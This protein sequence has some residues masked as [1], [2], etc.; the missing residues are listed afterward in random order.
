MPPAATKSRIWLDH[1]ATT[2]PCAQAVAAAAAALALPGNPASL[3][4][5]GRA[6]R[7]VLETAREAVAAL[8]GAAPEQVILTSGG[9]EALALAL[10]TPARVLALATEHSAVRAARPDAE[11]L[12]VHASGLIDLAALEAA[13]QSRGPLLVAV[14]HANNETGVVQ[15]IEAVAALCRQHGA[16]LLVDCVQSAGKLPLPAADYRA[17]SAHK[18]GGPMGAGALVLSPDAPLVARPG[19]Q[20][21][22]HRPGTPNLPGHAGWAAALAR[23]APDWAAVAARRDAL[24]AKM[25]A[26]GAIIHGAEA[27]RLPHI[28]SAGLPG[29]PASLQLMQLDL[30]GF[31][32]SAGA[33]CSSGR[34]GPSPVLAAM[35]LG[36]AAGEAIRISLSPATTDTELHRFLEAW[37]GLARKAAA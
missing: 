25:A 9:T 34:S 24:Q 29:V 1:A 3:H 2:P 23:P 5:E 36:S 6:A 32:V 27:P 17:L 11:T 12:P 19:T 28:L 15:P 37:S 10:A 13:L 31:A 22:G 20:E 7:A 21:R 4:A 26:A 18:M 14:Q 30:A 35:G 16:R 8:A 33:A